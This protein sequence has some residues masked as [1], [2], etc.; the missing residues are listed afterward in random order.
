[1]WQI[2]QT[3]PSDLNF[4]AKLYNL[5]KPI[6]SCPSDTSLLLSR[7][8]QSLK[9]FSHSNCFQTCDKTPESPSSHYPSFPQV[10]SWRNFLQ[11]SQ[12]KTFT[13]SMKFLPSH[14]SL[15]A[16]EHACEYKKLFGFAAKFIIR[17]NAC[18]CAGTSNMERTALA[19]QF[20][21]SSLLV[22]FA[23]LCVFVACSEVIYGRFVA[24]FSSHPPTAAELCFLARC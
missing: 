7:T 8:W 20:I 6:V 14:D 2:P 5:R 16:Y 13:A 10:H 11:T 1:M 4:L 22:G 24:V 3:D 21:C 12:R 18:L 17:K 9:P 15:G 23:V 19:T